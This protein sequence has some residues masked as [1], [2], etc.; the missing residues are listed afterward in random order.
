MP[1]Q[2]QRTRT[3]EEISVPGTAQCAACDHISAQRSRRRERT[4][5]VDSAGSPAHNSEGATDGTAGAGVRLAHASS[6][7]G[8]QLL[9][10][11][12]CQSG[13][14]D[15]RARTLLYRTQ[16]WLPLRLEH[17]LPAGEVIY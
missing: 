14:A 7:D 13:S 9:Y 16:S 17:S 12:S 1:L 6:I 2:T 15:R 11:K 8:A 3:E 4:R 5:D 10:A